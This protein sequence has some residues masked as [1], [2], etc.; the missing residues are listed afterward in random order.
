[1]DARIGYI[2]MR[3]RLF[4]YGIMEKEVEVTVT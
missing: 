4:F 2:W 3:C 1:M